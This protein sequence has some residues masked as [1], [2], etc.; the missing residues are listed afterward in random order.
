M[1]TE[2]HTTPPAEERVERRRIQRRY[3]LFFTRIFDRQTGELVGNLADITPQGAMIITEKPLEVGKHFRL[4]M[5]LPEGFG[6]TKSYLAFEGRSVWCQ[7]DVQPPLWNTGFELVNVCEA[8][9]PV[10]L[11]INDRYALR[12]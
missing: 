4:R 7:P 1:T 2:P 5:D 9:I 6:F 12:E 10:I 8:D 3:L 11:E